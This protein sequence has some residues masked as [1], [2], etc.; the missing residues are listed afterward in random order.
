MMGL[1]PSQAQRMEFKYISAH[2]HHEHCLGTVGHMFFSFA[3]FQLLD[4]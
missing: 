1:L 2:R 3:A 4:V